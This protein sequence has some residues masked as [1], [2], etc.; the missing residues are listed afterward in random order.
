MFD[1]TSSVKYKVR[2]ELEFL[3]MDYFQSK[4]LVSYIPD[5]RLED[6]LYILEKCR[7]SNQQNTTENNHGP[8]WQ[9]IF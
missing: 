4:S 3:G 8:P 7:K 9:A 2:K 1:Y 5:K 6:L